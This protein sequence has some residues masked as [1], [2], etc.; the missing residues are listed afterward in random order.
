VADYAIEGDIDLRLL[1][2]VSGQSTT[3]WSSVVVFATSL[4]G[5][6]RGQVI[7]S[8]HGKCCQISAANLDGTLQASK[9]ISYNMHTCSFIF[10][11]HVLQSTF[12]GTIR[13]QGVDATHPPDS[14]SFSMDGGMAPLRPASSVSWRRILKHTSP[15]LSTPNTSSPSHSAPLPPICLSRNTLYEALPAHDAKRSQSSGGADST[16]E[17]QLGRPYTQY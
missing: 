13:L 9:S 16:T 14:I 1:N 15:A 7:L 4:S 6:K 11:L 12:F 2:K 8:L 3:T 10:I 5:K 17:A